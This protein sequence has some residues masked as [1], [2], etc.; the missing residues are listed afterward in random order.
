MTQFFV[1]IGKKYYDAFELNS[2]EKQTKLNQGY[3][4]N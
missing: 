2:S 1:H 4:E 3:G